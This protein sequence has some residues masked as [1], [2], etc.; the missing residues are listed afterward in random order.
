[1]EIDAKPRLPQ[2]TA[3]SMSTAWRPMECGNGCRSAP[4]VSR[5]A[6]RRCGRSGCRQ[7]RRQAILRHHRTLSREHGRGL[8]RTH[9]AATS[10]HVIDTDTVSDTRSHCSMWTQTAHSEIVAGVL[11]QQRPT[12]SFTKQPTRQARIGRRCS[13][14]M[15]Y[16]PIA[17]RPW[18]SRVTIAET[19]SSALTAN[20]PMRS[21]GTEYQGK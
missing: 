8:H 7:N 20:H 3:E 13:W 9:R 12:S 2:A 5:M 19:I 15:T 4:A 18:I 21:S 16:R 11:E 1:M 10:V 17:A 6:E 14:T